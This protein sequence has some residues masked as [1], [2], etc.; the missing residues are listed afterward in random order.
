MM[1]ETSRLLIR[2]YLID[3]CERVHL[4]GS[5][6]DFSQYE[7]WGPNSIEDTRSFVSG[8]I[9]KSKE[10]PR[11]IY[12][13]AVCLKENQLQIGGCRLGRETDASYIGSLGWAI[14]PDFQNKGYAT[15]A[16]HALIDFGFKKLDLSVIY[17]TCDVR[18]TPSYKVMEKLGMKRV[19]FIKGH[20]EVKG[21]IRDTFRYE[22]LK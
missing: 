12:D 17:A 14:N 19:G 10:S 11:F 18:N 1:I 7:L 20:K 15:E 3:D 13:L 2:D 9:E 5:L 6:P 4:Y 8:A 16:A 21:H 22:L